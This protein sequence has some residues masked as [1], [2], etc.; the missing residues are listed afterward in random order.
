MPQFSFPN[1]G[2]MFELITA[3]ILIAGWIARAVSDL[4]FDVMTKNKITSIPIFGRPAWSRVEV[5]R[6]THKERDHVPAREQT[7]AT[8]AGEVSDANLDAYAPALDRKAVCS[9][10]TNVQMECQLAWLNEMAKRGLEMH[11]K[12][13]RQLEQLCR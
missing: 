13:N 7:V 12:T 3:Q 5:G 2:P 10:A 1:P 9:W 6:L 11:R 4:S 8:G